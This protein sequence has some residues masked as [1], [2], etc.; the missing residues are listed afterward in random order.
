MVI[1]LWAHNLI[2][3]C[4]IH[5]YI[6]LKIAISISMDFKTDSRKIALFFET[7][8]IVYIGNWVI[9]FQIMPKKLKNIDFEFFDLLI[10]KQWV[11]HF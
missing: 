8:I 1:A 6:Q 9:V 11:L 2:T 7:E 4:I 5:R 3:H 10:F